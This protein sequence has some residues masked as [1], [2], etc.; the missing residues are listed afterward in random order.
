MTRTAYFFCAIV[1]L[2]CTSAPADPPKSIKSLDDVNLAS[3]TELSSLLDEA[4]PE[5][6][7]GGKGPHDYVFEVAVMRR[8]RD[9]GTPQL[10]LEMTRQ[11]KHP[12]VATA[13]FLCIKEKAPNLTFRAALET[14]TYRKKDASLAFY[15]PAMKYLTDDLA[16]NEKNFDAFSSFVSDT[17]PAHEDMAFRLSILPDGFLRS[18]ARRDRI[19]SA[20]PTVQAFAVDAVVRR[21]RY[22][23]TPIPAYAH[24]ML[25]E[26]H[27]KNGARRAIFVTHAT[28]DDRRLKPSIIA[29]LKDATVSN[30]DLIVPIEAQA[31]YIR[32]HVKY[33]EIGL[34]QARSHLVHRILAKLDEKAVSKEQP[35][36]PA[37]P[38][39]LR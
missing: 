3:W 15:Y 23:S 12:M 36:G 11:T 31:E 26:F 20:H 39:Q 6:L 24:E 13:G 10:W 29:L 8:I 32:D 37:P 19:R 17:T 5:V 18:W 35:Q 34:T 38:D 25:D 21:A 27:S 30:L 28:P 33:R 14:L 9:Q 4:V 7:R 1:L 16:L 22:N 2:G